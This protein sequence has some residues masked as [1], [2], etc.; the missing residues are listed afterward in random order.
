M[1]IITSS[2]G[3]TVLQQVPE[4]CVHYS[5]QLIVVS[6]FFPN[7]CVMILDTLAFRLQWSVHVGG[8][9]IQSLLLNCLN[10]FLK[11]C[12]KEVCVCVCVLINKE[13]LGKKHLPVLLC[14]LQRI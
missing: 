4:L 13:P 14:P 9:D 6:R 8:Q 3:Q 1:V 5:L 2:M 10:V 11:N 12:T 7:T